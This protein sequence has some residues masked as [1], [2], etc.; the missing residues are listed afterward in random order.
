MVSRRDLLQATGAIIPVGMFMPSVFSK[1]L[2]QLGRDHVYGSAGQATNNR[3]LIIVQLAGGNDGLNTIIPYADGLYRDYRP[4]I[5][6]PESQLLPISDRVAL[7]SQLVGLKQLYDRG[8][9][10]I[11]Q[12][13]GYDNPSLS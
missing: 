13:V 2:D 5:G 4:V 12:N 3:T 11:M 6:V 7:N 1:A 8:N 9:V 10:A